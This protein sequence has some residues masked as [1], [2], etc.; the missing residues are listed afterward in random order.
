MTGRQVQAC[1]EHL[2]SDQQKHQQRNGTAKGA[3]AAKGAGAEQGDGNVVV[4]E[5]EL[6]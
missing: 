6:E 5:D 4:V 3:D 2:Q 1:G